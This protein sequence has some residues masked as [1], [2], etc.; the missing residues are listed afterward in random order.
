MAPVVHSTSKTLMMV[1]SIQ[2]EKKQRLNNLFAREWDKINKD[3]L[4]MGGWMSK[5]HLRT[6]QKSVSY[7][8]K[9]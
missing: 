7:M 2:K 8:Q 4:W 9:N 3:G 5:F 1:D 6:L